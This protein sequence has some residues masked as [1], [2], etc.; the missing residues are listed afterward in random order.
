[1]YLC[2]KH[3]DVDFWDMFIPAVYSGALMVF[4]GLLLFLPFDWFHRR[5]ALR[6]WCLYWFLYESVTMFDVLVTG[7]TDADYPFCFEQ[8]NK[9]FLFGTIFPFILLR[10]LRYD[11]LFW[12]GLYSPQ[13]NSLNAPLMTGFGILRR[14]SVETIAGNLADDNQ[15]SSNERQIRG[16]GK[17]ACLSQISYL[18]NIALVVL[19]VVRHPSLPSLGR[20][21][22]S[23]R[24]RE[25][26][27]S[28]GHFW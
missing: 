22:D 3:K 13:E 27:D 23:L 17:P 7:N 21:S 9:M 10:T 8:V 15:V 26:L 1:M 24:L 18:L 28:T 11:S 25:L 14:D 16:V 2:D 5:P 6:N 20:E 4:Y 19:F 12:Q